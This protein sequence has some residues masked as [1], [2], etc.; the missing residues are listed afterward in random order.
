MEG[1]IR[2]EDATKV[3]VAHEEVKEELGKKEYSKLSSA[4]I[5]KLVQEKVEQFVNEKT[6]HLEGKVSEVEEKRE[7]EDSVK[8][9]VRTTKDFPEYAAE[10]TKWFEDHPN[11]Y[12]IEVAYNAVKGR[13]WSEKSAKEQEALATEEAKKLAAN[14]GGG[15]SQ[16]RSVSQEKNLVDQL[17]SGNSNPNVL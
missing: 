10:V 8:A 7:F 1:K 2:I 5:E 17:I 3:A 16:G 11:Q 12:D 6:K 13:A 15:G 9:F 4:E 14:A